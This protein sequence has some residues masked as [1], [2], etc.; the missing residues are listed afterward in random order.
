MGLELC[1]TLPFPHTPS[2]VFD[3][4]LDEHCSTFGSGATKSCLAAEKSGCGG[5][6]KRLRLDAAF[7]SLHGERS[8]LKPR[9]V[10]WD[11]QPNEEEDDFE[12]RSCSVIYEKD[13]NNRIVGW[14]PIKSWMKKYHP[15]RHHHPYGRQR[16]SWSSSSSSKSKSMYV[17]VKMKGAARKIDIKLFN[18]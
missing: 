16:A 9:L 12:K 1:L 2:Q 18:S 6:G 17:N 14:P 3:F 11:R 10:S 13:E 5:A 8:V 15:Y 4:D 7:G